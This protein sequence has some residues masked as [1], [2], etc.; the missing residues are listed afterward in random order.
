MQFFRKKA[1]APRRRQDGTFNNGPAQR[2]PGEH[3]AQNTTFKR[4]RTLTGSVS[5]QVTSA[6][7]SLA[8]LQSPRTQAHHLARQRKRLGSIFTGVLMICL[9]IAAIL[10]ELTAKPVIVASEGTIALRHDRYV[11]MVDQYLSERPIERLRFML[12]A[13]RLNEYIQRAL[14]EVVSISPGGSAGFGASSFTVTLRKPIVS[15]LIGPTQYFV[16]SHGVPFEMNYYDTPPVRIID[17]SG[18]QQTAGTAIASSRFLN[19]VGRAVSVAR[20]A[21]LEVEQAII[22][23]DTTRQVQL[24]LKGHDYPVKFSLDRPVGEQVEDMARAVLYLETKGTKPAYI[25]VRVSG[26]VF[27]K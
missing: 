5:S 10:Y 24:R 6:S 11:Q 9:L 15:W 8:G 27:Y 2:E 22:P 23:A 26:R 20:G 3:L 16:D 13:Q 18:I 19:F 1:V 21:G 7:E 17:Q 14:P 12:N 25:D 4:N